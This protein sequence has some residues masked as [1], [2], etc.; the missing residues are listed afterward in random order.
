MKP[1]HLLAFLGIVCFWTSH[2]NAEL[3]V[4]SVASL[5]PGDLREF[6]GLDET[7][8]AL[9]RA[10]LS[11][12][13]RKLHYQFGSNDPE[14]GGMDCSGSVQ[15]ILKSIGLEDVPRS[16]FTL[17]QWVEKEGGLMKTPGVTAVDD[18]VFERL[19]PGDLLFWRGTYEP[20]KRK[21]PI[22]HVMIY[23]GTL[24]E[25][26]Q[27]VVFGASDGR[28]FRGK[29]IN[30]V[31]VF[32]WKLPTPAS[33]SKFVGFAPVPGLT[34]AEM[35]RDRLESEPGASRERPGVIKSALEKLLRRREPEP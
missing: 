11:L 15:Y 25:D 9:I 16:S 21:P 12:T 18:P 1:D 29:R 22:S 20:G 28:R 31:S 7:R 19:K 8:Q 17:Y 3:R 23:L 27:G 13:T 24:R 30:G 35:G 2:A 33:Q 34:A 4:A 32:D 26:G 6:E 5:S 14:N 10:A